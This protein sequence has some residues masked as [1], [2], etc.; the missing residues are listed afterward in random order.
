MRLAGLAFISA[1][2]LIPGVPLFAARQDVPGVIYVDHEH[3]FLDIVVESMYVYDAP[4]I[5]YTI[6]LSLATSYSSS[7]SVLADK[8]SL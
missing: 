8:T 7:Y 3:D 2:L 4:I 6:C 5:G 1:A